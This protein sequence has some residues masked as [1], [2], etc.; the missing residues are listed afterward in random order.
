[1]GE[2][3]EPVRLVVVEDDDLYRN[4]LEVCLSRHPTLRVVATYADSDEA[5]A[6]VASQDAISSPNSFSSMLSS[7]SW[8]STVS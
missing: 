2:G 8:Y 7:Y 3:G 4:L 6:S 1:M 5:L